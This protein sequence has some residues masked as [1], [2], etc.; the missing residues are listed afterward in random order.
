MGMQRLGNPA[1]TVPGE[2][3]FA[4][5]GKA[6]A[7]EVL[8]SPGVMAAETALAFP[9]TFIQTA[10]FDPLKDEARDFAK[11]LDQSGRLLGYTCFE[12]VTHGFVNAFDHLEESH[13]AVD[14][15]ARWLRHL[16]DC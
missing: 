15:G 14:E 3:V 13:M 4:S 8:A 7:R 1:L 6:Q 2:C 10:G 16:F 9:K 5:D 11:L 12:E